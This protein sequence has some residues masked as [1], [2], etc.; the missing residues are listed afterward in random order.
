VNTPATAP[1]SVLALLACVAAL[2][3]IAAALANGQEAAHARA[4]RPAGAIGVPKPPPRAIGAARR[5]TAG[6][7]RYLAGSRQTPRDATPGLARR[8]RAER[9]VLSPAET[10]RTPRLL[11]LTVFPASGMRASVLVGDG[12]GVRYRLLLALAD[13]HGRLLVS[14]VQAATW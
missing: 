13:H 14:Q 11:A 3:T 2:A 10:K 7:L 9:P 8:L 1:R 5:F 6:Y 12:E 4:R